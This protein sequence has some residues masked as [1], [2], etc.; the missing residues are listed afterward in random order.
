MAPSTAAKQLIEIIA[1][2][3][4]RQR[5]DRDLHAAA[6]D[7][8]VVPAV[9]VIELK[10]GDLRLAFRQ[11]GQ[12]AAF[13]LGLDASAAQ[14]AGLRA[15]VEH[16][17]RGAGLLRRAAA[18]LHQPAK[19]HATPGLDGGYQLLQNFAHAW[20]RKVWRIV[21]IHF[22]YTNPT[23]KRGWHT[24]TCTAATLARASG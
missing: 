18:R 4:V 21:G 14:R 19:G 10:A 1:R 24:R 5:I 17:H 20:R 6:A 16:Q 9:I 12:G 13:H 11:N 23:R 2:S 7:Q 3:A 22:S 15:V 8:A